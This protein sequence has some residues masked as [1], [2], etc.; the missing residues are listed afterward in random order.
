MKDKNQKQ[1]EIKNL[2]IARL[3]VLPS[4]VSISIGS[5]GQFTRDELIKHVEKNDKIGKKIIE[6]ELE[7]LQKLKEG[8]FYDQSVPDH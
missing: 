5:Q 3:E 2:V 8:I 4:D 1:E 6:V 7:Y